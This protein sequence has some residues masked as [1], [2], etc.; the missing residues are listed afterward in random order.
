MAR[1]V[2]WGAEYAK[3]DR[4]DYTIGQQS[5]YC[6]QAFPEDARPKPNMVFRCPRSTAAAGADDDVWNGLPYARGLLCLY[7]SAVP[8]DDRTIGAGRLCQRP[9]H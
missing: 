3:P 9:D 7:V 6:K 1:Q 4:L 8:S 5:R 2:A